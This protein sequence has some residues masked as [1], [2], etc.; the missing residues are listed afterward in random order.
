MNSK[1]NKYANRL[2]QGKR[3]LND[4]RTGKTK[5]GL[6]IDV[7]EIDDFLRFKE[8]NLNVI[9]GHSNVGKTTVALYFM[10]LYAK[11]LNIKW[12]VFSSENSPN[13]IVRKLIEYIL[14][15]PITK[16]SKSDFDKQLEYVYEHFKIVDS[17]SLYNYRSLIELATSIKKVWD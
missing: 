14:Q 12:L 10:L 15:K 17:E 7:P 5:E 8:G 3:R 6:K 2:Q 4:I 1:I 13:S 16:I 11:R 9:L